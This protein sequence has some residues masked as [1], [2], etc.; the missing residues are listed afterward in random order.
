MSLATVKEIWRYPV[1]SMGGERLT[2]SILNKGGIPFDR[3]WAVRDETDQTI[4][5]AKRF[6]ALMS[7]SARYLMDTPVDPVPKAEVTLPDGRRIVTDDKSMDATLSELCGSP[8]SLWPLQPRE[9]TNHYRAAQVENVEAHLRNIFSL[10]PDEPLPNLAAFPP[11]VL[12]EISIYASPRGTY[13][14]AFPV[15]IL[16][17]AS[18]RYMQ[19]LLPDSTIDVRRFRPNFLVADEAAP[20]TPVEFDWVGREVNLGAARINTIMRCP[21]C[22]MTTRAQIG[23]G[24]NLPQDSTIMRALVRETGQNLSVYCTVA[25]EGRVVIGDPVSF[26]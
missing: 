26:A 23:Q 7:C 25:R 8:V 14:D 11:E 17:E 5:G 9:D 19:A 15:N 22:I 18:L 10:E 20:A 3:G 2:E 6:E 12:Q 1:K 4:K 21:R 16:T 13:F 24:M